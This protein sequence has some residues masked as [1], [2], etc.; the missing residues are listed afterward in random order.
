MDEVADAVGKE[1]EKPAFFVSEKSQ[2]HKFVCKECEEFNDILGRFGYCSC[3]GTRNDLQD[4][5]DTTI[6]GIRIRLNAG[7]APEDCVRDAVAA[8][9]SFMAQL[10]AELVKFIP[11]T[12]RRKHRLLKQSFHDLADV[13]QT[14][15]QW[16]DVDIYVGMKEV[17]CASVARMFQRRHVYEH[18]AGVVDQGYL[19][20]TQDTSVVLGQR[21]RETQEGAHDFLNSLVKMARNL[22]SWFQELFPP[23]DAPIRAFQ[24]KKSRMAMHEA[25]WKR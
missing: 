25:E 21:I 24:E 3:C 5:E 13:K 4:F 10:A 11:M 7:H 20:K 17:E 1:G 18:N 23:L 9:D 12:G 2:Q 16:F 22:H 19:D 6:P 14:F 8:F 15:A